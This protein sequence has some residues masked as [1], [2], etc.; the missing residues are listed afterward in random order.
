MGTKSRTQKLADKIVEQSNGKKKRTVRVRKRALSK[1]RL[2][3]T[4]TPLRRLAVGSTE[5]RPGFAMAYCTTKR[6][7]LLRVGNGSAY[8]EMEEE[9]KETKLRK[10]VRFHVSKE[11]AVY[12]LK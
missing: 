5:E 4:K 9:D 2:V 10:Y 1:R 3:R 6:G 8:V 7:R 12:P 11:T